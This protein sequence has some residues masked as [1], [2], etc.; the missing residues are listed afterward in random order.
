VPAEKILIVDDEPDLELLIRQRFRKEIRDGKYAFTFARNGVE[1]LEKLREDPRI[2]VVLSDINMPEMDGLTLL[3]QIRELGNPV[4]KAVIVSAYGDMEN[5]RTAMNRGAFDFLTK[6]IDFNDLQ[7]TVDKTFEQLALIRDALKTRDELVSVQKELS[8]AHKIQQSILPRAFPGRPDVEL[9]S[10]MTPAKEVGGDFYDWFFL[11]EQRLALVIG[12]VSGKGVPAAIYMALSRTLLKATAVSGLAPDACLD[13]VNRV[14]C[15]ESGTGLFVTVFYGILDTKTGELAYAIGGH[16]PP[17]VIAPGKPAR[18]LP[19]CDSPIVGMIAK[20]TFNA[21]RITLAPGEGLFLFSDGVT[22]AMN[23]A[24]EQLGD[25]RLAALLSRLGGAPLPDL[26]AAV[27]D[28]VKVFAGNAPQS[29]DLTVLAAR[30]L[31]PG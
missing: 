23:E 13:R 26:V 8:I 18:E 9:A 10:E 11:D 2:E 21:G 5:I 25:A 3:G 20:A 19:G 12:D 1:A 7:I 16:P 28:E 22:E 24:D 4:L 27:V 29:D 30:Y 17:Y 15:A 6:P 31:G 14:L